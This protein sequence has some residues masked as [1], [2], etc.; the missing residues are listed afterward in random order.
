M[1]CTHADCRASHIAM[2]VVATHAMSDVKAALHLTCPRC[3]HPVAAIVKKF[4]LNAVPVNHLTNGDA[5]IGRAGW[6]LE[7]CWPSPPEPSY[8]DMIPE[9]VLNALKQAEFNFNKPG[10]EEAAGMMYR[11]ALDN[12]L[13]AIDPEFKGTLYHRIVALQGKGT[14]TADIAQW[15]EAIRT[16]GNDAA[17]EED[18]LERRDLSQLKEFT[19]MTL[20]Y[21]FTMPNMVKKLREAPAA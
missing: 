5:D 20:R 6:A 7:A 17:H 12:A 9:N 11:K 10:N 13:K 3:A 15:A 19:D 2:R 4:G 1:D 18:P 21:L 8:P 14:L 16:L